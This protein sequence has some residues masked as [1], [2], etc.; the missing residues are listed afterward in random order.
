VPEASSRQTSI[1][2]EEP[3]QVPEP[4]TETETEAARAVPSTASGAVDDGGAAGDAFAQSAPAND[5]SVSEAGA[6]APDAVTPAPAGRSAAD[7]D[8]PALEVTF[9]ED[10]WAEITDEDGTRLYYA[11]GRAGTRQR[12]P[13]DR[14]LKLLFGN[15][16]GVELRLDGRDIPIPGSGQPGE[17]A[18]F[19]L[20]ALID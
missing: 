9:V 13:A 14:H 19:E 18:Q 3:N 15:A 12:F 7:F 17:V 16:H 11:L 5:A 6:S 10:S 1:R 20:D 8:G 4:E 2:N